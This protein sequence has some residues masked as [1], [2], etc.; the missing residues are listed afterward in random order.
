LLW[1]D[2]RT[3]PP[4]ASALTWQRQSNDRRQRLGHHVHLPANRIDGG[5]R[6]VRAAV[7]ARHG[8]AALEAGRREQT[9]VAK[10][11]QALQEGRPVRRRQIRVDVLL[12]ERQA[13]ER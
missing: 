10:R 2:D 11:L 9:V 7:V 12:G 8:D 3:G 13:S 1:R 4:A 5:G 6:E